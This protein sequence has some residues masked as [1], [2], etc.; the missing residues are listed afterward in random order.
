MWSAA[1]VAVEGRV[2]IKHI[3]ENSR[4]LSPTGCGFLAELQGPSYMSDQ[5]IHDTGDTS[6]QEEMRRQEK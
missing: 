2:Y 5:L 6:K 1:G 3:C 4:K